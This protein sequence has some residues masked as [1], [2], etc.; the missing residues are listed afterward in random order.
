MR[1]ISNDGYYDIVGCLSHSHISASN[2]AE[3]TRSRRTSGDLGVN[4]GEILAE[5]NSRGE[6]GRGGRKGVE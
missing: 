6:G 5:G 3:V 2:P 1:L 4:G